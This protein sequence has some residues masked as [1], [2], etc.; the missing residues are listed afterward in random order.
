MKPKYWASLSETEGAHQ[1]REVHRPIERRKGGEED[2]P[3]GP[4][5]GSPQG[6]T[7]R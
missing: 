1:V 4:T 2:L 7:G 3:K 5:K 6:W